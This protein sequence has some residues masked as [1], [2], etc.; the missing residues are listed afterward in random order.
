LVKAIKARL[1]DQFG[2]GHATIEIERGE[3]ADAPAGKRK[4]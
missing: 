1:K 4:A 2:L 3:C